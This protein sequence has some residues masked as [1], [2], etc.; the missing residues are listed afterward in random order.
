[1]RC[2]VPVDAFRM[3]LRAVLLIP[4]LSL[5]AA[6][7][8]AAS[9]LAL[10]DGRSRPQ[11][12]QTW[13]D[14]ARVPTPAEQIELRLERCPG[15]ADAVACTSPGEHRIYMSGEAGRDELLHE[16]GHRFDYRMPEWARQGFRKIMRDNALELIT[17]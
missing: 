9:V 4:V 17:R 14:R 12:F 5:L 3:T 11:P 7:P 10:P 1:M 6:H 2:E 8:A 13:V 16:L 15:A